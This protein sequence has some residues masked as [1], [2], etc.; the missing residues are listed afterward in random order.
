[1]LL[2]VAVLV[3]LLTFLSL[4]A[5]RRGSVPLDHAD[6]GADVSTADLAAV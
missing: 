2:H 4:N 3:H 5:C 6:G 1:M